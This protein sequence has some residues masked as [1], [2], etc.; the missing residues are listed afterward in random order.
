[1]SLNA[2]NFG[3]FDIAVILMAL[4]GIHRGKTN[5]MSKELLSFIQWCVIVFVGG[6]TYEPLGSYVSHLAGIGLWGGYVAAY[7]FVALFVTLIFSFIKRATRERFESSHIFGGL[8]YYLGPLAGA[9]KFSCIV[10]VLVAVIYPAG[11]NRAERERNVKMQQDNF[12]QVLIPSLGSVRQDVF[13]QSYTG[14]WLDENLSFLLI[15]M[16]APVQA[17][18]H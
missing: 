1:M 6:L 9:V 11:A 2:L 16:P 14:R 4:L 17:K 12:G 3:W 5:G 7:V 13:R 18:S 15:K 8:E 10:L